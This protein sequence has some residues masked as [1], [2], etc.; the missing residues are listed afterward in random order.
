MIRTKYFT[1]TIET[2]VKRKRN[3]ANSFAREMKRISLTNT[4]VLIIV[5]VR[6]F[7][8]NANFDEIVMKTTGLMKS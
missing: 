7:I 3:R 4:V 5:G 8:S 1:F 2:Q 6:Q